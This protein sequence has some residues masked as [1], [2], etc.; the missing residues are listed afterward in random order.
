MLAV[1]TDTGLWE[2]N[3][4]SYQVQ[5]IRTLTWKLKVKFS[6][7]ILCTSHGAYV[8]EQQILFVSKHP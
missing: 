2:T 4:E 6:F 7:S 5:P 1:A 8:S 3:V